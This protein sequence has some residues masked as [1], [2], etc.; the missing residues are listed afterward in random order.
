[1]LATRNVQTDFL[2]KLQSKIQ[3]EWLQNTGDHKMKKCKI[4]VTKIPE[5]CTECPFCR[6]RYDK[7]MDLAYSHSECSLGSSKNRCK[8][9]FVSLDDLS[10]DNITQQN[11]KNHV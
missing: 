3:V 6:A 9:L 11:T 8:E 4:V 7:N 2:L 5:K 1:M 10:V